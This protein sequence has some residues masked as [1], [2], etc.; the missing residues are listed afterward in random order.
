MKNQEYADIK[1]KIKPCRLKYGDYVLLKRTGHN[2]L[3]TAFHPKPAQVIKTE[4]SMITAKHMD[5]TVTRDASHFKY[6]ERPTEIQPEKQSG[7]QPFRRKSVY[8]REPVLR[9]SHRHIRPVCSF[10]DAF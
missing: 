10:W 9:G 7:H 1:R 5:K 8:R 3:E 6:V 4:G 2:E